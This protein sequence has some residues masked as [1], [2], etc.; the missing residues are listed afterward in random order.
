MTDIDIVKRLDRGVFAILM[1]VASAAFTFGLWVA[2]LQGQVRDV[3]QETARID[4]EGSHGLQVLLRQTD[5]LRFEVRV[6]QGTLAEIKHL[7]SRRVVYQP[8]AKPIP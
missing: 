2:N 3:T 6:M 1:V 8:P 5:S 7:V 4:R